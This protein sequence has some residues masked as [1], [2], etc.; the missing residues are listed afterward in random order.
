M[1]GVVVESEESPFGISNLHIRTFQ[2]ERDRQIDEQNDGPT[3]RETDGPK[4]RQLNK[5]FPRVAIPD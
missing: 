3:N 2:L 1:C 5:A 4:N